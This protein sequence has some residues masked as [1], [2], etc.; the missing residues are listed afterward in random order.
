[1]AGKMVLFCALCPSP[2]NEY[3]DSGHNQDLGHQKD[4][5]YGAIAAAMDDGGSPEQSI[6][7]DGDGDRQPGQSPPG[8]EQNHKSCQ[9]REQ[10][11]AHRKSF[12]SVPGH[13]VSPLSNMDMRY[14]YIR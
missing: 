3:G 13:P 1:M 11:Q 4:Q 8:E 12:T 9:G 2:G 5:G 14:L 7:P 10:K 6:H